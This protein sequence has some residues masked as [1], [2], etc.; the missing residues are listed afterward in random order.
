MI[1]YVFLTATISYY[2]LENIKFAIRAFK[3]KEFDPIIKRLTTLAIASGISIFSDSLVPGM[4]AVSSKVVYSITSSALAS[5]GIYPAIK[6]LR[7]PEEIKG[8]L[9][10]GFGVARLSEGIPGEPLPQYPGEN[11]FVR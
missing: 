11:D 6:R 10:E 9:L 3:T 7:M 5:D 2:V 8:Q 1:L 4:D